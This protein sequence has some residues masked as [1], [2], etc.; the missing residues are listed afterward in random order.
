MHPTE[1]NR[2]KQNVCR[3]KRT[4]KH[5]VDFQTS[6]GEEIRVE[7]A[8]DSSADG[9]T[10]AGKGQ[11]M[12]VK[13]SQSLESALDKI[14]PIAEAIVDRLNAL[15]QKPSEVEVEFSL[16]MSAEAGMVVASGQIEA[17]YTVKLKWVNE[18]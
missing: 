3:G 8:E 12:I 5:F 2:E 6:T 7:V 4:M 11:D 16:K 1:S 14:R 17:N 9:I 10:R 18:K 15:S 13:A